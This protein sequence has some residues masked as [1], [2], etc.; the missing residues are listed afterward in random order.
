LTI[1]PVE[2]PREIDFFRLGARDPEID[3]PKRKLFFQGNDLHFSEYFRLSA[4]YRVPEILK[5]N[6]S[7]SQGGRRI[8]TREKIS[9]GEKITPPVVQGQKNS[10][11]KMG[12]LPKYLFLR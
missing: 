5:Q 3:F 1:P 9:L 7:L 10:L 4:W 6:E 12:G 8:R 2:L 11:A